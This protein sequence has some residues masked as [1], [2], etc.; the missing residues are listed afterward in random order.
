MLYPIYL[1]SGRALKLWFSASASVLLFTALLSCG[2][3]KSESPV[4]PEGMC[5][6]SLSNYG[7]PFSLF[8][9]DTSK[10]PLRIEEDPSGALNIMAG[11]AFAL[12]IYEQSADLDMKRS[13]IKSDEVN[14]LTSFLTDEPNAIFWES[15]ITEPEYHFLMNLKIAGQD[16]SFQ[17]LLRPDIKAPGKAAVQKMFDACKQAVAHPPKENS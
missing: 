9:P 4:A 7:K 17:D 10:N 15:A 2:I 5:I 8:V 12:S 16:Y 1:N 11:N 6:I 3:K 14:K 13:D